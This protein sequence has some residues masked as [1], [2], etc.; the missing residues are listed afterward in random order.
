MGWEDLSGMDIGDSYVIIGGIPSDNS[1]TLLESL[2]L[3]A[4]TDG[5]TVFINGNDEVKFISAATKQS[6][7]APFLTLGAGDLAEPPS[8]TKNDELL[9]NDITV[10]RLSDGTSQRLQDSAS[11][12]KYGRHAK[13]ID[14]LLN[15]NA[16]ARHR[17]GYF[18]AFF[19]QP[20]TRFDSV[21][22][23]CLLQADWTNLVAAGMWDILRITG[24]PSTAPATQL[25]SFIEGREWSISADSW[26]L[27]F[28]VS[29]AIPFAIVGDATRGL[30]GTIVV[31]K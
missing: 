11:I 23:E 3:T 12:A 14:T 30:T 2:Q 24:L 21:S 25:D 31:G 19:S 22:I 29:Y 28:D 27:T 13:S 17:A 20:I 10:N 5:G 4:D 6:R 7:Y 18:I 16:A 9:V 15:S 26:R 8:A 1:S